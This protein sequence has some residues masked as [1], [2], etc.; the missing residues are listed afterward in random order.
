M[1]PR[2]AYQPDERVF[3]R[4]YRGRPWLI[5]A[6][7]VLVALIGLVLAYTKHIPF[8]SYGYE[9]K[10]VFRNAP[11]VASNTPVRIAGVNVG[12]VLSSERKGNTNEMTFTVSDSGRPVR[13]DAQVV[14]R[15]RLFLEGNFYLD[16]EP[17]SPGAP[18]L[19]SGGTIPIPNTATAV[20]LDQVLGALRAPERADLQEVLRVY[21]RALTKT[22][23]P[24][25][26]AT[27]SPVVQGVNAAGALNNSFHYGA[28]A[29]KNTAIVSEALLGLKEHDLSSLIAAQS[30]VF[31]TLV[32]RESQLQD[33]I[34]NFNTTMGALA[35][36]ATNLATTVGLLPPTLDQARTTFRD[37]NASFPALRA[38][39]I[40]ATPGIKQL[41][42]T[43]RAGLPWLRQAQALLQPSEL[44]NLA[45][46]TRD[47]AP[48]T[49]RAVKATTAFLPQLDLTSRCTTNVLIPA[50]DTVVSDSRFGTGEPNSHEF[51]YGLTNTTSVGQG[52]DGNGSYLRVNAGGGASLVTAPNKGGGFA[53]SSVWGNNVAPP[54]GVQPVF[55]TGKL[56]PFRPDFPCY[57]NPVPDINGPAGAVGPPDLKVA[58]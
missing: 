4:N 16:L 25:E 17:G 28:S 11:V 53:N 23:T 42:A 57:R 6:L 10:A 22:P 51:F 36:Q 48:A 37:L 9:L 58:P 27:Q 55:K 34:T 38:Y 41:P 20:Q 21:G 31:G 44:G 19:P 43:I 33:L 54:L 8:T 7:F 35:A 3:G 24:A 18:E 32:S 1:S 30:R 5:G 14:I 56:P 26:D 2:K 13:R 47:S 49:A 50:G 39:A 12:K 40:S 46:L 45:Q 52:F 29:G 15:P